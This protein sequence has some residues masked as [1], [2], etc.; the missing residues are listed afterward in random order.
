MPRAQRLLFWSTPSLVCLL[1]Y[2]HGLFAWFQM[3][4][5]AWLALRSRVHDVQSF[6][7]ALFTPF[8]Q[9]TIR[10]IS[11]RLFFMGMWELFGLHALPYRLVV[12][13]TQLTNLVLITL[14]VRRL[15]GSSLAAFVAPLLWL[16]NANLF[17]AMSWTAAYNQIL[18]AF[19]FLLGF[20]FWLKF[21]DSGIKRYYVWQWLTFV[22]GFGVLELNVVYPAIVLVYTLFCARRYVVH[23]LPMFAV[24]IGYTLMHQAVRPKQQNEIY[25]LYFDP[26]SLLQTSSEYAGWA[27]GAHR[28]AELRHITAAPFLAA[29]WIVGL[30]LLLFFVWKVRQGQ[31]VALFY[32]GWALISVGPYLL[33]R[34]H[35]SQYYLTVP[36]IGLSMLGAWA[37]ASAW[38]KGRSFR[39]LAIIIVLA[40]AAPSAWQGYDQSRQYH[41]TSLKVRD[42]LAR[43]AYA[44]RLHPDK[45]LL[46]K[47]VDNDLF[48]GAWWDRAY[49][50][51]GIRNIYLTAD[52]EPN[53]EPFPEGGTLAYFFLAEASAVSLLRQNKALVYEVL[54]N[55]MRNITPIYLATLASRRQLSISRRL[56]AGRPEF[57]HQLGEGWFQI[58]DDHRWTSRR[59]TL[60]L[61]GTIDKSSVFHLAGMLP[62]LSS[63]EG[64]SRL[65]V[66]INGKTFPSSSLPPQGGGFEFNYPLSEIVDSRTF[67]ITLE[68]DRTFQAPGDARELGLAFGTLEI[69]E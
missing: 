49:H 7:S 10:P 19:C 27:F 60:K 20:Y 23:V 1:L 47:G 6:W 28:L 62:S 41:R 45:T 4:D 56:D 59:A 42:V 17:T 53:I 8:A 9:G 65:V 5:F 61:G 29:E 32:V 21:T 34:S 52:T 37:F 58:E 35:P 64:P 67:D 18:I 30:S 3:D 31:W 68:V 2:W 69:I 11:E 48:W 12:F 66:T 13:A 26:A 46:V 33:L 54:P 63:N 15:S 25:R 43:L 50:L 38:Q 51:V 40:Y 55:R 16:T 36:T 57:A 24:S 22:L 44:H 14:I 39:L